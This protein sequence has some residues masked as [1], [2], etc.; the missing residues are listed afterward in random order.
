M[1]PHECTQIARQQAERLGGCQ[2]ES[3]TSP[4]E[5]AVPVGQDHWA[6][7]A[8]NAAEGA[9]PSLPAGLSGKE[10]EAPGTSQATSS[11]TPTPPPPQPEPPILYLREVLPARQNLWPFSNLPPLQSLPVRWGPPAMQTDPRAQEALHYLMQ[12][13]GINPM[14]M[15]Q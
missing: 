11:E 2:R 8:P 7:D 1:G 6:S 9:T 10:K 5:V 14:R 12:T 4:A 3:P 15:Q 13:F